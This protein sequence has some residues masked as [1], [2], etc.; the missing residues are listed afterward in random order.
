MWGSQTPSGVS[1]MWQ[2]LTPAG[3]FRKFG[4][5]AHVWIPGVGSLNGAMAA[6]YVES[7][8]VT[9]AAVDGVVGGAKD[10]FGG[11]HATQATTAN[12]PILRRG[13]VNL[14]LNSTT[15]STQNVTVPAVPMTLHFQNTGTITLSGASTAG[16]LIG[17][18]VSNRV[19]I[20]FTPTAGTLTLTVTGTVSSAQLEVGSVASPYI[21]TTTAPASSPSG[22][23]AWAFDGVNDYLSL[24]AVPF[25]MS[26]DHC[27]ISCIR[28]LAYGTNGRVF[29]AG[30]AGLDKSRLYIGP[31]GLI[32]ANLI[33]AAGTA[34]LATV[35]SST[36]ALNE[37]AVLTLRHTQAA[38]W[39]M[40]NSVSGSGVTTALSTSTFT[41]MNIATGFPTPNS[42]LNGN[43]YCTI[44]IK[45]TVT[46]AELKILERWAG[47]FG[48]VAI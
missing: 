15:L 40:K 42:F 37:C 36:I 1:D 34:R 26:D 4:T 45:G 19:S 27:F 7:T 29:E 10:N 8:F 47:L 18:D 39:A 3:I 14:L 31:S 35:G 11:I 16:P 38:S 48:G 33:D 32:Y 5:D 20:T 23:Q 9:G 41:G 43:I 2:S 44:A 17:T 22:K 24:S 13:A 21:P 25:Q 30:S 46:D 28:P 12:K 6:N